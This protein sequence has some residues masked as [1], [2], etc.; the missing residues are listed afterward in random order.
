MPHHKYLFMS[1]NTHPTL[2]C[3]FLLYGFIESG[4]IVWGER[5]ILMA[6]T[7]DDDDGDDNAYIF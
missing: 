6:G 7:D 4:G 2:L 5:Q 3:L 1:I